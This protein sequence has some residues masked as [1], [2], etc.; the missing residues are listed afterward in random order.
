M[1]E[2]FIII[3]PF[4]EGVQAAA[5]FNFKP[6]DLAAHY[7]K[8]DFIEVVFNWSSD[9]G[10]MKYA[11]QSAR[12][13]RDDGCSSMEI[14]F[15]EVKFQIIDDETGQE[16]PWNS[17]FTVQIGL[18]TGDKEYEPLYMQ[19]LKYGVAVYFAPKGWNSRQ[20]T[21]YNQEFNS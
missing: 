2:P 11:R 19:N 20:E 18:K 17:F 15:P 9:S 5:K 8:N 14:D 21:V 12:D 7:L 13:Y 1:I 6:R 10:T 16:L 4:E 3:C